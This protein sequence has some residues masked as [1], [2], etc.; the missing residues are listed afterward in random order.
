MNERS[1]YMGIM[2][3]IWGA[4][5]IL[6]PVIGGL[7]ADSPATWRWAFYIN[8][9]ILGVLSPIFVFMI[10]STPALPNETRSIAVRLATLDWLGALLNAG[11]YVSW[12]LALQFGGVQWVWS[13]GRT[14]ATF[15]VCGVLIVAF[16]LQ[17]WLCIGT[18]KENRLFPVRFLTD[19]TIML[20]FF[21][22]SCWNATNFVIMFYI[23]VFF[24]FTHGDSGIDSAVRLLPFVICLVVAMM[25]NGVLLPKFPLYMPWW[26]VTGVLMTIGTCTFTPFPADFSRHVQSTFSAFKPPLQNVPMHHTDHLLLQPSSMQSALPPPLPFPP[27]TASQF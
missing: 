8:L 11:I 4:G 25:I 26:V 7:F 19:R 5:T 18:S 10:P 23:P 12:V 27:F 14:I 22:T 1:A 21:L 15:V 24:E 9:V 6:G 17:Q 20:M 13:D 2:G 3:L 16:A